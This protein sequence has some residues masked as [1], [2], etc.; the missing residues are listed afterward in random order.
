VLERVAHKEDKPRKQLDMDDDNREGK[1]QGG[2]VWPMQA[3]DRP[4]GN[5]S[6]SSDDKKK[7]WQRRR[8]NRRWEH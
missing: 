1:R 7:H 6:R 8:T 5:Q 3:G 4:S 2:T